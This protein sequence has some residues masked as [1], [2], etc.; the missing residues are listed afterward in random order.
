MS[1]MKLSE[2]TGMG[3]A[4][5]SVIRRWSTHEF[6]RDLDGGRSYSYAE[7]GQRIGTL[8]AALDDLRVGHG[9]S[10]ATNLENGPDLAVLILTSLVTGTRLALIEPQ[11]PPERVGTYLDMVAPKAVFLRETTGTV[12]TYPVARMPWTLDAAPG[13]RALPESPTI[14]QDEAFVI[15]SS[16]TTG[17]PKGVVHT[18]DNV[19]AEL[20]AMLKAYGFREAMR[21]HLTLPLAHVS[22]LYRSFL[23]P[24]CTGGTVSLRRGFDPRVFWSDMADGAV[25]FVQL[26]PS[27]VAVLN[28][29]AAEPPPNGL[30][31]Q[32]VGTASAHLPPR[33]QRA[34][35][36]RFGVPVLQG[37][38]LT[39][40]TCGIVLNSLDPTIRRPG[41]VGFP[42][43]VNEIK[44]VDTAGLEVERGEVGEVHVR[45]RNVS[46]RYLGSITPPIQDGWLRTGDLG[47]IESDGNLALVGRKTSVVHRGAYKIYPTEVEEALAALPGLQEAVVIGV[48]HPVLGEDLVAFVTPE[49]GPAPLQLLGQLRQRLPSYKVP[50]RI[51]PVAEIPRNAMGK[52]MR[53]VLA[54][55]FT[56]D[57]ATP[58]A[59]EDPIAAR[60]ARIAAELFGLEPASVGATFSR[61]ASAEWDSLGHVRLL[62]AVEEA[63]GVTLDDEAASSAWTLVELANVVRYALRTGREPG[64]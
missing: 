56:E 9:D 8:I 43:E 60:L 3:Q 31:L 12:A 62:A 32:F 51:V 53:D 49:H 58:A 55:R 48:P 28:R 33:E 54:R 19:M 14:R 26:V 37:Y 4:V 11:T 36:D 40:T 39:E 59:G 18:H 13:K 45:G 27:H 38:G 30:R 42:L 63:F 47:R 5:T 41:V 34:F 17:Q 35:E 52:T 20:D 23:M 44:L 61:D 22:G 25:E 7:T 64:R 10:V 50:S 57:R 29:A 6:L 16:G 21:H 15:F 2:F 46:T 24:F 1:P